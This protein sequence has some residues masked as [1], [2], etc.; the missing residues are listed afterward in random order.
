MSNLAIPVIR[1]LAIFQALQVWHALWTAI[2]VVTSSSSNTDVSGFL[3]LMYCLYPVIYLAITVFLWV[4]APWLATRITKG[5][6]ESGNKN[7]SLSF[8]DIF[9]T[10]TVFA[11]LMILADAVPYLDQFI[12]WTI[13][14]GNAPDGLNAGFGR[15]ESTFV[16]Y[17]ILSAILIFTPTGLLKIVRFTRKAGA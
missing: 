12:S 11:G 2:G 10:A 1:I 4:G 5:V 3:V 17:I 6:P 15:I 13:K 9:I 8:D 14:L 7:I 16:L